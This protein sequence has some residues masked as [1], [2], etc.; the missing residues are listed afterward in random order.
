MICVHCGLFPLHRFRHLYQLV[1]VV[2]HKGGLF[3]GHFVTYRRGVGS[4]YN[5][6][7]V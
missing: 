7:V 1:A 5:R 3:Y 2:V 4:Y 6:Y